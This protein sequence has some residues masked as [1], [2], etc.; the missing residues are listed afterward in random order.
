M[1]GWI[2]LHSK[3]RE[4]QHYSEPTVL[5]VFI[6]ILLSAN[7]KQ[8]YF[9][10]YPIKK[11]QSFI[12]VESIMEHTLL[13]RATVLRAIKKL[14]ESGEIKREKKQSWTLT[15][16]TKFSKYQAVEDSKPKVSNLTPTEILTKIPTEIP[17]KGIEDKDNIDNIT[18]SP[19]RAH[20]HTHE[21]LVVEILEQASTL[22]QFCMQNHI[23]VHEFADAANE[24]VTEWEL[25]DVTHRDRSD[26]KRH[27]FSVVRLKLKDK[28]KRNGNNR[29]THNEQISD[30]Y[31]SVAAIIARRSAEDDARK[32]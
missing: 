6:D 3:I 16:I 19:K 14:V 32:V 23:S 11:G 30:L 15:T 29:K 22:E 20:A 12:S 7:Y 27:L 10:G 25:T 18:L 21:G 28:N 4:W 9:R 31:A 26:A 5:V 1:E 8:T 24:V 2:K 13:S 17:T